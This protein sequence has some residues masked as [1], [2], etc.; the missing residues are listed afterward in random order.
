MRNFTPSLIAASL[1]NCMSG[2]G[3]ICVCTC[4]SLPH[5]HI[6]CDHNMSC[7]PIILFRRPGGK[8]D[9]TAVVVAMVVADEDHFS[10]FGDAQLSK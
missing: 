9:D 5:A 7:Y 4:L 1:K 2:D 6:T 8:L 3:L 10:V